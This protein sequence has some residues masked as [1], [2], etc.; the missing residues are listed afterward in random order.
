MIADCWWRDKSFYHR[1]PRPVAT[2]MSDDCLSGTDTFGDHRPGCCPSDFQHMG[3]IDVVD[4]FAVGGNDSLPVSVTNGVITARGSWYWMMWTLLNKLESLFVS[5]D[6]LIWHEFATWCHI[7]VN[8]AAAFWKKITA[9]RTNA[10]WTI[11]F[12]Y[13]NRFLNR[14]NCMPF[15]CF[16]CEMPIF[17]ALKRNWMPH[18]EIEC[19]CRLLTQPFENHWMIS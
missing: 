8:R 4:N 3:Y 12:C 16:N 14:L 15:D 1:I 13:L 6:D 17:S 18:D 9:K 19:P 2:A 7:F 11:I 10:I 5:G